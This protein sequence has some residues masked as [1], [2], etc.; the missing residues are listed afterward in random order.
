MARTLIGTGITD[1]KGNAILNKDAQGQSI[2][3]Y[4]G[5]G[6]GE[7]DIIAEVESDGKVLVSN[8]VTIMDG[9]STDTITLS[10][11]KS[12]LSHA[13]NDSALLTAT[14]TPNKTVKWYVG[15]TLVATNT[16]DNTGVATYTYDSQ[17]SGDVVIKAMV[18][19][20]E[21]TQSIEDCIKYIQNPTTSSDLNISVPSSAQITYKMIK[22]GTVSG[23]G[24]CNLLLQDNSSHDYYI[25]NWATSTD[26]GVLI[27]NHGS[28]SNLVDQRCSGIIVNTQHLIGV[29]YDN[30]GNW[31][32]FKDN[33]V[34]SFTA[35]YIPTKI[36]TI[37]NGQQ[38]T[39][40][41]LKVKPL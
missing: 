15:N 16:S 41:D 6:A 37:D 13:D 19:S 26:N 23:K 10:T 4:I 39:M 17:G 32:Y 28:S 14:T 40:T 20:S 22:T 12:V 2:E 25:G 36:T 27:R 34:K 18:G 7:V 11:N 29:T 33:E 1:N 30:N 3:G 35:N 8:T 21:A 38:S 31:T 9:E 5:T 24:G